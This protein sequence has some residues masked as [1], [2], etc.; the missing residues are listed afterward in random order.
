MQLQEVAKSGF[1][2]PVSPLWWHAAALS[3]LTVWLYAPIVSPLIQLWWQDPNYLHGF[4]VPVFSL[5]L[6]WEDRSRLTALPLKPSW[7]GLPIVALAL[8]ALI[9]G[10]ASTEFFLPRI[11]LL[12]LIAGLVVFL[13]G[14]KFLSAVSFP[15]LF[16]MLMAPSSAIYS[17][18]TF[19]LQ[20]FASR[21]ASFLLNAVGISAIREGNVILLPTA[22][23]EV[24][25]ACSGIHSLFSLLTIAVIY[26]HFSEKKAAARLL[27]I[28]AAIPISIVANAVR[29]AGTGVLIQHWG[30]PRVEGT[31][32][33]LSGWLVFVVSLALLFLFHSALHR[34]SD[35]KDGE[36]QGGAR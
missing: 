6:L 35:R 2:S 3:L 32:H 16:L 25:E 5:F 18:L 1:K 23:M 34:L 26:G 12:L 28:L 22:R 27:L 20:L 11:S 10:A 14:W 8:C 36:G 7:S 4:L 29:I 31:V 15:L 19:P 30:L 21:T 17:Q 33:L 24:A 13:A 9:I